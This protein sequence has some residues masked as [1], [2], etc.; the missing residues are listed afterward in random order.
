LRSVTYLQELTQLPFDFKTIQ[1]LLVGN[2]I[3]LD[4]NVVSYKKNEN[5][6]LLMNVNEFFKNLVTVG[7]SDFL[8]QHSKLDDTDLIRNR[9]CDLTYSS[10]ERRDNIK[11][12][13]RRRIT[14]SE[15]S[16]LDIDM[17]FKQYSFNEILSYPFSIPK[18]YK[19]Q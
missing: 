19:Q 5:N 3:Y 10:Y 6:I 8:M 11:F 2:P 13:T 16:K 14:V 9:T 1:D 17:E 18:N 7:S 12:P 4:S 15:K